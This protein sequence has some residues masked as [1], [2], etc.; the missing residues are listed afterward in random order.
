VDVGVERQV[1]ID[2]PDGFEFMQMLT[3]GHAEVRVGECKYCS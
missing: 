2:G 1:E 3:R